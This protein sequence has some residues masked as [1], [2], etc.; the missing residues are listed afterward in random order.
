MQPLMTRIHS[1][2]LSRV[3]ALMGAP[4][5]DGQELFSNLLADL[6]HMMVGA[7]GIEPTTSPV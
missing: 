4:R 6:R 7:V 2:C 3:N 5:N 1:G